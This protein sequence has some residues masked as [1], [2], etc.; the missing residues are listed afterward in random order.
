M[1]LRFKDASGN[2]LFEIDLGHKEQ[3]LVKIELTTK[4]FDLKSAEMITV[5]PELII[6]DEVV[7]TEH[8]VHLPGGMFKG[9]RELKQSGGNLLGK[10]KN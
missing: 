1:A 7:V 9:V 10:G 6:G 3:Q 5:F 8:P 2:V 4:L